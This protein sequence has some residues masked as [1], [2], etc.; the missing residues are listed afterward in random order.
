MQANQS[1]GIQSSWYNSTK[2]I[3]TAKNE[4]KKK[5]KPNSQR[6]YREIFSLSR[7]KIEYNRRQALMII[8]AHTEAV[9]WCIQLFVSACE[10]ADTILY[11][12]QHAV[13]LPMA[14]LSW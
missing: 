5:V 11:S 1:I 10:R 13:S 3:Q 12:Y 14:L 9:S 2:Y 8:L 6:N 7:S 4:Q